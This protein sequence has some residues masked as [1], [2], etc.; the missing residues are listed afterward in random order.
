M[1]KTRSS[2]DELLPQFTVTG[3]AGDLCSYLD[4]AL[5]ACNA[6]RNW[7]SEGEWQDVSFQMA[8]SLQE[9]VDLPAVQKDPAAQR[10]IGG[11]LSSRSFEDF[12]QGYDAIAEHFTKRLKDHE[13]ETGGVRSQAIKPQRNAGRTRL[14]L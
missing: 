7:P 9:L 10:L 3:D 4:E 1:A 6:S 12:L 8:A 5:S 2:K 14:I 13:N 11:L